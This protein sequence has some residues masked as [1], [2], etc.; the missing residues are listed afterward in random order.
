MFE[1]TFVQAQ[2]ATRRP[3]TVAVSLSLQV[4]VVG[5]ILLIPLLHPAVMRIPPA[6]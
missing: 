6:P 2:A 5:V 4:V 3:W 1:Q